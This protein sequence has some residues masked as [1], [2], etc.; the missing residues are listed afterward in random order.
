MPSSKPI[1]PSHPL[2]CPFGCSKTPAID[3]SEMGWVVRC[4]SANYKH[5]VA[6]FGDTEAEAIAAWNTRI[7]VKR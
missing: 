7:E 2:P 3:H 1:D 5:D 4:D 6:A